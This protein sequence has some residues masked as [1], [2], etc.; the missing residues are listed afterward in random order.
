VGAAGRYWFLVV[1]ANMTGRA[2]DVL[3]SS[4]LM[5]VGKT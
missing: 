5:C 1:G 3:E 4:E 2:K